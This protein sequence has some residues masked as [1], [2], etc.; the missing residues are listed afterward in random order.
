MRT[1]SNGALTLLDPPAAAAAAEVDDATIAAEIV[2][3]WY[4]PMCIAEALSPR[5]TVHSGLTFKF[6]CVELLGTAS[7][8]E[9]TLLMGV[10]S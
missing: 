3:A 8:P 5:F 10:T 4:L 2:S 7:A 9:A 1:T 6:E